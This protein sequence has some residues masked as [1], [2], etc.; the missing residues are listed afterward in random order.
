MLFF[1]QIILHKIYMKRYNIDPNYTKFM[2]E[3]HV[4]QDA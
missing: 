1:L 4:K 2:T 3:D